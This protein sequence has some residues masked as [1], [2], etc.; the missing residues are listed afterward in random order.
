M[1]VTI[2][3]VF[4]LAATFLGIHSQIQAGKHI[5]L[6]KVNKLK[7]LSIL[8][9]GPMPSKKILSGEGLKYH[10]RFVISLVVF[11]LAV[12]VLAI[13]KLLNGGY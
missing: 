12:I 4:A 13:N 5:S 1:L 11:A 7:D 6:E 9:S 3:L 8:A 2:C 10:K